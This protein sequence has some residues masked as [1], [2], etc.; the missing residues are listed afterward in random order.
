MKLKR[1][2]AAAFALCLVFGLVA[3]TT[4]EEGGNTTGTPA[5]TQ[6]TD[7]NTAPATQPTEEAVFE[8]YTVTVVDEGGNPIAGAF[9]QLCLDSCY[10]SVTDA[11]G[12]AKFDLEEADYKVSFVSLPAGY[13]YAGEEQE[14]YFA[15]GSKELTVTLKTV[16]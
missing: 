9:V 7:A 11:S 8:G 10:P 13:D 2:L 3:C 12:I 14:F 16:A 6:S 15:S 5:T 4:V 1:L